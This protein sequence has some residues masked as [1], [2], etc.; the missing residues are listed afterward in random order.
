[1]KPT[2]RQTTDEREREQIE[3]ALAAERAEAGLPPDKPVQM[4]EAQKQTAEKERLDLL[5]AMRL[6]V[7]KPVV[8]EAQDRPRATVIITPI[9]KPVVDVA[10]ANAAVDAALAEQARLLQAVKD[11]R[12]DLEAAN[13]R[14]DQAREEAQGQSH[15]IARAAAN[16]QIAPFSQQVVTQRNALQAIHEQYGPALKEYAKSIAS[17]AL[18]RRSALQARYNAAAPLAQRLA[19]AFKASAE[20]IRLLDKVN[21]HGPE[22]L[23]F[24]VSGAVTAS[25]AALSHDPNKIRDDCAA[26]VAAVTAWRGPGVPLA[27]DPA[28]PAWRPG[29]GSG[30]GSGSIDTTWKK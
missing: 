28:D 21:A 22:G 9:S 4:S 26:L 27:Q 17:G 24:A 3:R 13:L 2:H 6:P 7:K 16:E 18:V 29:M 20:A 1:M 30:D 12:A 11:A 23:S 5:E 15:E 10:A 19:L 8:P 25:E 14:V